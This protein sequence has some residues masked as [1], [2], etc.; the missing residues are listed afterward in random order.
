MIGCLQAHLSVEAIN[1]EGLRGVTATVDVKEGESIALLPTDLIIE[2]GSE[3]HS[4]AV[5]HICMADVP[6]APAAL[7]GL[8]TLALF[9]GFLPV[10]KRA[11]R[12]ACASHCNDQRP[13]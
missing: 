9:P 5:R 1:A 7:C 13:H 10:H 2:M 8:L 6:N 4:S 3:R 11:P 12:K